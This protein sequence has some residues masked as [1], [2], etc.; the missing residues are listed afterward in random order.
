MKEHVA[1]WQEEF[2]YRLDPDSRPFWHLFQ[3]DVEMANGTIGKLEPRYEGRSTVVILSLLKPRSE[4]GGRGGAGRE[5]YLVQENDLGDLR[6]KILYSVKV[7][8]PLST[9]VDRFA[10]Q[11]EPL[12]TLFNRLCGMGAASCSYRQDLTDKMRITLDLRGKTVLECLMVL[13]QTAG[14]KALFVWRGASEP[15]PVEKVNP[16]HYI[17]ME[18]LREQQAKALA[19]QPDPV[20]V[21]RKAVQS[22]I[23]LDRKNR[24]VLILQLPVTSE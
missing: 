20:E 24:P 17:P 16:N 7:M 6:D 5:A 18:D 23:E 11:N 12:S 10:A 8:D 21:L 14:G 19:T 2:G 22:W 15:M 3:Q 4:D 1:K 13:A 9:P